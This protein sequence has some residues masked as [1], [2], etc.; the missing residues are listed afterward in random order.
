MAVRLSTL[1]AGR[2][3]PTGRC[4]VFISIKTLSRSLGNSA[5]RRIRTIT[6]YNA[7]ISKRTRDLPTSSMVPQPTTLLHAPNQIGT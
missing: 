1:R 6:K 7:L 4:L 5:A 3:L 2:V